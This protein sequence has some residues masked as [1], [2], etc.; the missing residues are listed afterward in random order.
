MHTLPAPDLFAEP[1]RAGA[2]AA[3]YELAP[4]RISV[5]QMTQG[6]D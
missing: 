5:I 4:C 1:L 6:K 2:V 3:G